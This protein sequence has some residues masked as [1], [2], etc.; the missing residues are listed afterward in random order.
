MKQRPI[1]YWTKDRIDNGLRRYARELFSGREG[2]LPRLFHIYLQSIPISLR[3]QN[4]QLRLYPPPS[5]VLL[6]YKS[7]PEAW[8]M[9][10]FTLDFRKIED[11]TRDEVVS[12]LK[13]VHAATGKCPIDFREYCE[14]CKA[15]IGETKFPPVLTILDLFG[16]IENAWRSA[17]FPVDPRRSSEADDEFISDLAREREIEPEEIRETSG[18]AQILKRELIRRLARLLLSVPAAEKPIIPPATAKKK[19]PKPKR[20]PGKRVHFETDGQALC[21]RNARPSRFDLTL[22]PDKTAVSCAMCLDVLNGILKLCTFRSKEDLPET[23]VCRQCKA[24]KR[25][26]EMIVI[27]VKNE[28]LFRI[29]PRCKACTNARERSHRRE[30]KRQYQQNWRKNNPELNKSY[31]KDNPKIRD[32]ARERAQKRWSEK[33]DAILIQGR[34]NRYGNRISLKK[35]GELLK[36]FGHCYPMRAG[37]TEAG[38][39]ECERIRSRFRNRGEKPPRPSEIRRMVYEDDGGAYVFV[40][41]PEDQPEIYKIASENLRKWHRSKREEECL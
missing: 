21:R 17:G 33:R 3:R 24:E 6:F 15:Q 2:R 11:W 25:I 19:P 31:W 39:R 29:R 4:K 9:L 37:L 22:S 16:S 8:E 10:G 32:R 28:T 27:F 13:R 35:A 38:L 41:R 26:G 23:S 14:I 18:L 40:V 34:M 20:L 1:T 5:R 36:K 7:F 12:G 30:W